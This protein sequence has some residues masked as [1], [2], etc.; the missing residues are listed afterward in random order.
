[1]NLIKRSFKLILLIVVVILLILFWRSTN[2]KLNDS[3]PPSLADHLHLSPSNDPVYKGWL[4]D[5]TGLPDPASV[6]LL[7]TRVM[8]AMTADTDANCSA[9]PPKLREMVFQ[10]FLIYQQMANAQGIYFNDQIAYQWAHVLAMVIKESSGDTTSISDMQGNSF[11][12][13][14]PSTNLNR[15]QEI[16]NLPKQSPIKMNNQTNFGLTQ[17]S[18]DRLT[19]AF[20]LAKDQRYGTEFLE[21]IDGAATPR[22]TNLN[23]AIAIRRLIWFYQD[24]AQGRLSESDM[25]IHP[26]DIY[27]TDYSARYQT[28]LDLA[29]MYCGTRFMFVEGAEKDSLQLQNAMASIAYCKLGNSYNGYGSNAIDEKCFAAWVTLCPNLN[30]DIATLTPLSYFQTRNTPAVCE[31]TFKRLINQRF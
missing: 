17:L 31:S 1:M 25:R 10:H 4:A 19:N 26:Q 28:G 29:L 8:E 24:F 23:T 7:T 21:G 13:Y 3:A 14:S 27:N 18:S 16:L 20:N 2:S 30:L 9:I 5:L 12:T 22:Q 11:S 6:N 15:W